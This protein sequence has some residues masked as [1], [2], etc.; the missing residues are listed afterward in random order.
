MASW[1][2]VGISGITNGGKSTLTKKLVQNFPNTTKL[3]CQDDYFYPIDSPNHV[4]SP[5]LPNHSNWEVITSIDMDK[6][7]YD[8]N[9]IVESIPEKLESRP[10]L[11]LDG[12]ILYDDK[13][14]CSLCNLKYFLTLEYEECKK[15]RVTR[16]YDP[17]D[18]PGYF[19]SCVW[20]MYLKHLDS[21]KLNCPD[22]EFLDGNSNF[23][24]LYEK[25][26]QEINVSSSLTI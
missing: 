4:P 9:K 13:R 6:M 8:V 26:L 20:P 24:K 5:G 7:L 10:I 14:M 16:T 25:V 17:P 22:V 11:L 19:D 18:I 12:F 2:I 15:R 3:I 23:D 1:L 21:V